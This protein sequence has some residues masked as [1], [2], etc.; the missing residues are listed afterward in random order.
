[1]STNREIKSKDLI[2]D[3]TDLKVLI[4]KLYHKKKIILIFAL[5]STL[6]GIFYSLSLKNIYSSS[7]TFYPHYEKIDKQNSLR[8]LAGLAGIN[9][10]SESNNEMSPIL[11]PKLL[12]SITFKEEILNVLINNDSL[13]YKDYLQKNYTN[14]SIISDIIKFPFKLISFLRKSENNSNQKNKNLR[15]ISDEDYSLFKTIDNNIFLNINEDD[16]FI[17]L[18]VE[19]YNPEVAAIIATEANKILQKN[20]IN[21]KL[22]NINDLLKFSDSQVKITQKILYKLQD[23]LANF[24]DRN[25]RIKSDKFLNQSDRIETELNITK[26]IYNE[27][28]LTK[29]RISIDLRKNTPIFTIIN[30]VYVANEKISPNRGFLVI[31]FNLIGFFLGISY[32]LFIDYFFKKR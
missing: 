6:F 3:I 5:C 22:K 1:M 21:F 18:T 15:Y 4:N 7:S 13:S 30:P 17:E 14:K 9:L 8:N 27:L 25:I 16:G 23:S 10:N 19:D 31:I 2:F 32:I 28:S 29:E 26:N 12:K 20:I 24:K 11:Y